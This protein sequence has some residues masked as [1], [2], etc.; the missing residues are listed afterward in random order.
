MVLHPLSAIRS[1]NAG[2]ESDRKK[3]I[4]PIVDRESDR[5]NTRLQYTTSGFC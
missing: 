2:R 4:S 3:G 5:E 1:T